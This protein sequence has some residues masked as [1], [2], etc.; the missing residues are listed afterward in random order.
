MCFLAYF[1]PKKYTLKH[2]YVNQL[3]AEL[4]KLSVLPIGSKQAQISTS[5]SQK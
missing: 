5:V 3:F 4:Q 1:D 2:L